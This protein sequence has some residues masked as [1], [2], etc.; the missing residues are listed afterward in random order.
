MRVVVCDTGP[1]LHLREAEALRLLEKA[2]EIIV[3]S[4]VERE[5]ETRISNWSVE[6]PAW[7]RIESV[8]ATASRQVEEWREIGGLGA[9]EAEAI[10]LARSLA[11]WISGRRSPFGSASAPT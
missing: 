8:P 11:T 7:V 10:V 4:A 5:L 1:I 2:G 6:R 9:G 3:P